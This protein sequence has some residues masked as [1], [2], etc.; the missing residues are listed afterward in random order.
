MGLGLG[1]QGSGLHNI[2]ASI[3]Q[4]RLS[5]V[6]IAPFLGTMGQYSSEF[7]RPLSHVWMRAFMTSV[8]RV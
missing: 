3:V 5:G 8:P 7:F 1:V 2:G 4:N 6:V